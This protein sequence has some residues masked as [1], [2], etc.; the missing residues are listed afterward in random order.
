MGIIN[1][2][3]NSLGVS[4]FAA[5]SSLLLCL[6]ACSCS[7]SSANDNDAAVEPVCLAL[8]TAECPTSPNLPVTLIPPPIAAPFEWH[9]PQAYGRDLLAV[10]GI[11]SDLAWAVGKEGF[12]VRLGPAGWQTED[13]VTTQNLNAIWVYGE[14]QAWAVGDVGTII[15]H[16]ADGWVGQKSPT[17]KSLQAVFGTSASDVWAV[18][19]GVLIHWD[20]DCWSTIDDDTAS[21]DAVWMASDSQ[22]WAVGK[23]GLLMTWDGSC[24]KPQQSP[25]TARTQGAVD[26]VDVNGR[27]ADDVWIYGKRDEVFKWDGETW[28]EKQ[29]ATSTDLQNR[30]IEVVDGW[31]HPTQTSDSDLLLVSNSHGDDTN[32]GALYGCYSERLSRVGGLANT[33][34]PARVPGMSS[35]ISEIWSGGNK[36]WAVGQTGLIMEFP[37]TVHSSPGKIMHLSVHPSDGVQIVAS[38]IA[39]PCSNNENGSARLYTLTPSQ[40]QREMRFCPPFTDRWTTSAGQSV[41]CGYCNNGPSVFTRF[42]AYLPDL[43]I[44][45][46]NGNGETWST[47]SMGVGGQIWLVDSY[48]TGGFAHWN[49]L[50]WQLGDTPEIGSSHLWTNGT[51]DTWL[52]SSS[53]IYHFEDGNWLPGSDFD[54]R[55]IWGSG[56]TDMWAAG[57][58]GFQHWDG[59]SWTIFRDDLAPEL[60]AGS[61]ASDVW[62]IQEETLFHYDGVSWQVEPVTLPFAPRH[63]A[64][65]EDGT[66]WLATSESTG[67][68]VSYCPGCP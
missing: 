51:D 19:D 47:V 37:N 16:T 3:R 63:L 2:S 38:P 54:T 50:V 32:S 67:D 29:N 1:S 23:E 6:V 61:S 40:P 39:D 53:G 45:K 41:F 59:T 28:I 44:P 48:S 14:D 9:G 65:S 10:H 56:P 33:M 62:A 57:Q 11:G 7:D 36:L 5:A 34:E 52:A 66:V 12:T 42:E 4:A 64:V 30:F 24:W 26:W 55:S 27:G 21:L 17:S 18:G 8:P 15:R 46:A 49:G 25:T 22:G 20:G 35:L 13:R 43:E 68:L 60:I 58:G 31:L